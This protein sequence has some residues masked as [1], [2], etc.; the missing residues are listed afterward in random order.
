MARRAEQRLV[1]AAGGPRGDWR[2]VSD[3]GPPESS[4]GV[5]PV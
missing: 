1:S 3:A 4:R 2:T 5:F